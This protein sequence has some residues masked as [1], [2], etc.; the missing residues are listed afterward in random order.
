M[1]RMSKADAPVS[2]DE[3]EIEGRYAELGE[4]TVAFETHKADMDP[5]PLFRGLPDDRCQCPHWGV[6]QAGRIIFRY[7]DHD[8]VFTAGDAYYGAPG[9]LPLIFAGTELVEF[10]PTGP[11]NEMMGVVGKNLEAAR[12]AGL[13]GG[14]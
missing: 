8:E 13:A 1:P 14:A 9:H 2:L 12:A 11:L 7:A 10:S 5:A 6:V 3:P 4:Y